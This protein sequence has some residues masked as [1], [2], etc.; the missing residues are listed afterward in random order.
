MTRDVAVWV[1]AQFGPEGRAIILEAF[2]HW[3]HVLNGYE[4]FYVVSTKW[5]APSKEVDR[6]PPSDWT[7]D[8]E[9]Q[10]HPW[11]ANPESGQGKFLAWVADIGVHE[12]HIID[13]WV[14]LDIVEHEIGHA[15]GLE[16]S[17]R[18]GDLMST[19]HPAQGT[20]ID[21][22]TVRRLANLKHWNPSNMNAECNL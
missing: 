3:N 18:N 6:I 5:A 15:L 4:H 14:E 20:C 8:F 11:Y 7:V 13:G 9:S 17:I 1:D 19:P 10:L 12:I 2:D 22:F 16:H 21:D